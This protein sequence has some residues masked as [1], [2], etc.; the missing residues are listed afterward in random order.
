MEMQLKL[1]ESIYEIA[2]CCIGD[3][4]G[5]WEYVEFRQLWLFKFTG[6]FP[7]SPQAH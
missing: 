1:A 2:Q 6:A 3:P 7:D 5:C 4:S